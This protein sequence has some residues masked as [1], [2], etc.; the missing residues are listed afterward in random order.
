MRDLETFKR[1]V[2]FTTRLGGDWLEWL[3]REA[4]ERMDPLPARVAAPAGRLPAPGEETEEVVLLDLGN[5]EPAALRGARL[6]LRGD[7]VSCALGARLLRAHETR[8]LGT[9]AVFERDAKRRACHLRG[10]AERVLV[11][12]ESGSNGSTP[13][14]GVPLSSVASTSSLLPHMRLRVPLVGRSTPS[15]PAPAP[16][17]PARAA[18]RAPAPTLEPAPAPAQ[19]PTPTP[20]LQ[21][22]PALARAATVAQAQKLAQAQAATSQKA[23]SLAS[24]GEGSAKARPQ[25]EEQQAEEDGAGSGGGGLGASF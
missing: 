5:L 25:G 3:T 17:A 10:T 8:V 1:K 20:A 23:T 22:A 12:S 2:P 19:Q 13:N 11:F 21:P 24:I 15:A 16:A 18:V 14:A 4:L 6:V 7:E 9:V